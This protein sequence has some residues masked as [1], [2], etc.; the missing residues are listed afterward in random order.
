MQGRY[1]CMNV[2]LWL[3]AVTVVSN[4]VLLAALVLR[5]LGEERRSQQH[6]QLAH[7]GRLWEA[8]ADGVGADRRATAA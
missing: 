7:V 2:V 1:L 6:G 8:R 3:S 5:Y 4:A